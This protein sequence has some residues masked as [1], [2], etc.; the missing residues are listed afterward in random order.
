[1]L[2]AAWDALWDV[3]WLL[4]GLCLL[5]YLAWD[6]CRRVRRL[7]L[8]PR[9]ARE[10]GWRYLWRDDSWVR[11]WSGPP[12]DEANRRR[13][14]ARNVLVGRDGRGRPVVAFDLRWNE[15]D[16]TEER[17][18]C[19]VEASAPLPRVAVRRTKW[20]QLLTDQPETTCGPLPA[21]VL[22]R[23]L[24]FH[25]PLSLES[26]GRTLR[27]WAAGILSPE[28]ELAALALLGDVLE[29]LEASPVPDRERPAH[30]V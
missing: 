20:D 10:R 29:A 1:M 17:G 3:V 7:V 14:R 15:G 26:E 19:A 25:P 4:V 22:K 16:T 24:D 30:P 27:C 28:Q 5:G 8:L 13:Q 9:W 2:G 21:D 12:F 18:V 6:V 23:V 11:R